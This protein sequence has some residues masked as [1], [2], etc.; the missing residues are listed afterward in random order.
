MDTSLHNHLALLREVFDSDHHLP[1]FNLLLEEISKFSEDPKFL[2][3]EPYGMVQSFETVGIKTLN[4]KQMVVHSMQLHTIWAEH[5][6]ILPIKNLSVG[7]SGSNNISN[8]P[9]YLNQSTHKIWFANT[10]PFLLRSRSL[11]TSSYVFEYNPKSYLMQCNRLAVIP[12]WGE[13]KG[14]SR[15]LKG[16][17]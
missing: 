17:K 12:C 14:M 11:V 2:R 6:N 16:R 15:K 5:C 3:C 10:L 13:S 1:Q 9:S 7:Q 8:I 4:K